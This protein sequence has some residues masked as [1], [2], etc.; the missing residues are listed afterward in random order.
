MDASALSNVTFCTINAQVSAS[1]CL[2]C[3]TD[4]QEGTASYSCKHKVVQFPLF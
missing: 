1:H 2:P 4:A 3:D